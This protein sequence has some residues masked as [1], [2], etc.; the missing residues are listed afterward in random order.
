MEVY[1]RVMV[2]IV[3]SKIKSSKSCQQEIQGLSLLFLEGGIVKSLPHEESI[4]A[5]LD[6]FERVDSEIKPFWT[7]TLLRLME[8][9]G[10]GKLSH[11]IQKLDIPKISDEEEPVK[12]K[13][14]ETK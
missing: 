12:P 9:E 3:F 2:K 13:P 10:T 1:G 11:L 4:M 5:I 8:A 14:L 7:K 6:D